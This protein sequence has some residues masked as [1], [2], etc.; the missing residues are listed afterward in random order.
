M[1][2]PDNIKDKDLKVREA[3]ICIETGFLLLLH[4][5]HSQTHIFIKEEIFEEMEFIKEEF[6]SGQ[7]DYFEDGTDIGLSVCPED[8]S[9]IVESDVS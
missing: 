7:K 5:S 3:L 4:Y 9:T 8:D 6:E 2:Y 1:E